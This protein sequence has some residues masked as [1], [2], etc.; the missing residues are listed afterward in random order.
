MSLRDRATH[1]VAQEGTSPSLQSTLESS[2]T[3]KEELTMSMLDKCKESQ[4]VIQ[5]IIETTTD[6][7]G[8]LFE[9]L[10]LHEELQQVISKSCS[11]PGELPGNSNPP[12]RE[13]LDDTQGPGGK[14]PEY[15]ND[16]EVGSSAPVGIHSESKIP[17]SLKEGTTSGSEKVGH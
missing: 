10:F 17:D 7:E 16:S 13:D 15:S 4:P 12:E 3:L 2:E 1:P 11:N 8:M 9:A 6:D 5:R 14:L